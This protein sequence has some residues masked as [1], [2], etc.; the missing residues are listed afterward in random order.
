MKKWISPE[1]L[2]LKASWTQLAVGTP[3]TDSFAEEIPDG[4]GGMLQLGS[5]C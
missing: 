4:K 2:E 3:G 1:L 5:C